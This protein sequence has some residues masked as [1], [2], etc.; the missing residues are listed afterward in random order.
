[1]QFLIES[2]GME[3]AWQIANFYKFA[4]ATLGITDNPKLTITPH[5]G[6][7]SFG[8]YRPSDGSIRISTDGRHISDILRT[9]AHEL[10]H[11]KQITSGSQL[12]LE[13]LEY[14]AN[15]VAGMLMRDYNKMHPE[16]FGLAYA[17]PAPSD[18]IG[19]SQGAIAG[20]PTRPTGPVEFAEDAPVNAAG[21]GNVA[22]IGI[23]PDGEPG[24]TKKKKPVLAPILKRKTFKQ[25]KENCNRR[26]KGITS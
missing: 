12:D 3:Q 11:H 21:A 17:E 14:E 5:S 13:S 26:N 1:M 20:D 2:V 18:T 6:T 8:S 15:A 9:F 22:G 19:D 16:M 24:I 25:L 10:V 7:T 23:G 4:C